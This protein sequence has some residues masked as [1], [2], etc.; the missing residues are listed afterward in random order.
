MSD[1][2]E[3]DYY[4]AMDDATRWEEEQVFQDEVIEQNER[5]QWRDFLYEDDFVTLAELEV[6]EQ[7]NFEP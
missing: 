1:Y 3:F 6:L 4:D 7:E 5:E 2:E